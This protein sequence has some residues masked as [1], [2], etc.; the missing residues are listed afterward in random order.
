MTTLLK[1]FFPIL[2]ILLICES[3]C[4]QDVYIDIPTSYIFSRSEY[5]TVGNV[6]NTQNHTNWRAGA[7]NPKIKSN[8]GDY[9]RHTT[10]PGKILPTSILHWRLHSIGQQSPP[11]HYRDS[12][13][14]Y[15]WFTTSYQTWY[16]PSISSH[17]T[18]GGIDFTFKIP[19]SQIANNAFHAGKY[20]IEIEQDYGRSGFYAIEFTPEYFNTYISIAEDIRWLV[21][22]GFKNHQITSLD[23][24]RKG[25]SGVRFSL[26]LMEIGHTVDVSLYAKTDD[27]NIKFKSPD[28]NRRKF[29]TSVLRLESTHP[30]FQSATLSNNWKTLTTNGSLPVEIGNRSNFELSLSISNEDFRTHFFEAGTYTFQIKLDAR[31]T[32]DSRNSQENIDVS[33]SIPALSEISLPSGNTDIN[34]T[35]NT[36]VKYHEGQTQ[37]IPNQIRIS[38]NENFELYVK[39]ND[40]YFSSNGIQTDLNASVLEINVDGSPQKVTLSTQSQNLLKN[41]NPAL[42]KNLNITYTISPEAAQ[43]LIPKE[44]KAYGINVIYGF[45]AL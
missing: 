12:W 10:L 9:F 40:N 43:S 45:T 19:Q 44:K 2:G 21:F 13:P 41:E 4:A 34:F 14:G 26:G 3:A 16:H 17:Y 11:F 15:K 38:K 32:N 22:N 23:Q 25:S 28:G 7:L 18:S 30:S 42:D 29:D 20:K 27:K 35:F 24:F 5:I 8:S 31:N 39:S 36:M 6:M 33:I 1:Y 37:T